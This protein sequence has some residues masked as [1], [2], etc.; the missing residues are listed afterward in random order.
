[1]TKRFNKEYIGTISKYFIATVA[2]E[3]WSLP[4]YAAEHAAEAAAATE[5]AGLGALGLDARA[6]L[7]QV[8]NFSILLALLRLFAYKPIL[9]IL[10]QRRE[11][12]EEGLR[13]ANDISK[14]RAELEKEKG[15]VINEAQQQAQN[16]I[17][18][19]KQQAAELV[20]A[21]D[22]KAAARMEA[23]VKQAES[24]I[25]QEL[26]VARTSL[27]KEMLSLVAL[28]TEKVAGQKLDKETDAELVKQALK[29]T[30]RT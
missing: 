6:L 26:G 9:N 16:I 13:N 8:L 23:S 18:Q 19:S 21:A 22:A 7:F 10:E 12:I 28:A 25:E 5:G 1:M 27:K 30:E 15:D 17:G 20:R 4:V 11:K 24:K 3:A 2:M 14:I 29:E